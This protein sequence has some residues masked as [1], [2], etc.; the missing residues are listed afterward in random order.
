MADKFD[1]LIR[2]L[3]KDL[4]LTGTEIAEIL[5]LAMQLTSSSNQT[6]NTPSGVETPTVENQPT[7]IPEGS[8]SQ[9]TASPPKL[10]DD[11]Q[12]QDSRPPDS[13]HAKVLPKPLGLIDKSSLPIKAPDTS[14]LRNP[15]NIAKALRPLIQY[16]S[17]G[18]AILLDENATVERIA[19]LEGI[20][21]PVLKPPGEL[22]FD[23]ALVVDQSDSM[24]FWQRTTQELQQILKHYGI[25]RNLQTWGMITNKQGDICLK[26]VIKKIVTLMIFTHPENL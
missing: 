10:L 6:P 7:N 16:I 5:W 2:V 19:E 15:L 26:K 12:P 9:I 14:S 1:R 3:E 11:S 22:K 20:F 17:Y 24:I 21:I 8:V 4:K 13:V 25:F 23:V 18:K